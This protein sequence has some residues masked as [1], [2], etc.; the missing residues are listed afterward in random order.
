VV[1]LWTKLNEVK[2]M[3]REQQNEACFNFDESA[4]FLLQSNKFWA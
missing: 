3:E 1:F 2:K 4:T